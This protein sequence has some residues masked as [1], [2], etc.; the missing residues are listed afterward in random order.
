MELYK[1][2]LAKL[3]EKEEVQV[4]F[5]NVYRSLGELAEMKS[6]QALEEIKAIIENDDLSDFMCVEEIVCLFERLGSGCG[7]RHSF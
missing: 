6:Y 2:M 1:E 4:T 5:P 7:N 3:L